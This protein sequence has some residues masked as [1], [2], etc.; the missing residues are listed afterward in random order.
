MSAKQNIVKALNRLIQHEYRASMN[1]LQISTW[2]EMQNFPGIASHFRNESASERDHA[3]LVVDHLLKLN[4]QPTIP[5]QFSNDLKVPIVGNLQKHQ[6]YFEFSRDSEKALL[7][8]MEAIA[9]LCIAEKD[10]AT[11]A[12]IQG[13]IQ[14]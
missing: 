2:F 10:H 12:F 11:H 14:S 5:H 6:D 8:E 4:E 1:Y 13:R 3:L 9:D 7:E